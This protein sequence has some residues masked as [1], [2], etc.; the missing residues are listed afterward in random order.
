MVF[1]A[2]DLADAI[3]FC[4]FNLTSAGKVYE[5][6][7]PTVITNKEL[8]DLVRNTTYLETREFNVPYSLMK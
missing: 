2:T 8:I 6:Q 4:I 1:Q 3:K 5:L 7:G